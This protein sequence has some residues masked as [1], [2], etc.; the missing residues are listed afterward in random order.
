MTIISAGRAAP[1]LS[2]AG[3][4]AAVF[5]TSR[6]V[7]PTLLRLVLALVMFPHGA[8]HLLGWFGGYGFAGTYQ[9]MTSLGFPGPLA[10]VAIVTEF[11]AP[12]ALAAGLAGRV[13]ALGVT[14]LM[15]GAVTVH[16]G[17]GFFMNWFG[18]LPAGSE[19]FEYHLLVLAMAVAVLIAG[20]GRW[21]LDRWITVRRSP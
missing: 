9:W 7:A 3:A 11:L 2:P 5:H 14:A 20:S 13:A 19:G 21:S 10:A 8:Q 17:N 16:A 15:L 1:I 12:L 4:P 6:D 18:A